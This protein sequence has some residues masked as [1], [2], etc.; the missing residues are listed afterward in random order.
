MSRTEK[1][2]LERVLYV[3]R[4]EISAICNL[5]SGYTPGGEDI[6]SLFRDRGCYAA[7]EVLETDPTRKQA[8][9]YIVVYNADGRVFRTRRKSAQT[10]ARLH[11]KSSIGV[12]GHV[13]DEAREGSDPVEAGMLRELSEELHV[14]A[15]IDVKFRGLVNDETNAVGQVHLGLVF[16]C[17]VE[18]DRVSVKET[19]KMAGDWVELATLREN[20]DR[21]ETW[22]QFLLPHVESWTTF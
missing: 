7:R 2:L 13:S 11:G 16:S 14:P 21:L 12:G 1:K 8:I 5:E 4:R 18:S 15:E 9:P 3:E 10:E 19:E 17:R 6:Y 20:F 22:S